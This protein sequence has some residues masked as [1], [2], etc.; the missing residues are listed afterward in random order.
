M[1][2]KTIQHTQDFTILIPK[3]WRKEVKNCGIISMLD[4]QPL[5]DKEK[6]T[7]M[8][9]QFFFT[10]TNK[11]LDLYLV[12]QI[13][14]SSTFEIDEDDYFMSF[15]LS[16]VD[17]GAWKRGKIGKQNIRIRCVWQ[18][19]LKRHNDL[20]SLM[21]FLGPC[22]EPE[23]FEEKLIEHIDSTFM[24]GGFPGFEAGVIQI[25]KILKRYK[26]NIHSRMGQNILKEF[27]QHA[28]EE[29][30]GDFYRF[31]ECVKCGAEF[32]PEHSLE[33]ANIVLTHS[34]YCPKCI[35]KYKSK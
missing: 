27:V 25:E 23:T 4:D 31:T 6:P 14:Y 15:S 19:A 5:L 30:Y 17:K 10:V 24:F 8:G 21:P 18:K 34:I 20:Q 3:S 16:D 11:K 7:I 28:L 1:P 12:G 33:Y 13:D 26:I 35:D 2:R 22:K 29:Y 32:R 9:Y